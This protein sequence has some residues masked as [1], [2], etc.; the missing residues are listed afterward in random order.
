VRTRLNRTFAWH[1]ADELPEYKRFLEAVLRQAEDHITVEEARADYRDLRA[2]YH[3]ML[4]KMSPDIADF[5]LQ[6]DAGQVSQLERSFA[7]DVRKMVKEETKGSPEE[8]FERR[9]K[10]SLAHIE[11]FTGKLDDGQRELV[12]RHLAAVV[13]TYPDRLADRRYRQAETIA[14]ARAK[15][16]RPEAI[17]AVRRLLVET[18]SWRSAE[19]LKKSLARDEKL[20]EMVSAL[21]RTLNAEQRAHFQKRVRGLMS[22]INGLPTAPDRDLKRG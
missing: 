16:S 3:R 7:E 13:D 19:F 8:R 11:E 6:L 20:F 9:V 10:R 4:D 14:L 17:A 21:S 5:L 1:R 2:R 22:D 15:P 18:D 12:S